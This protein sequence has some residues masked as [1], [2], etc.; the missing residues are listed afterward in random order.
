[1][2][3]L[4]KNRHRKQHSVNPCRMQAIV[5]GPFKRSAAIIFLQNCRTQCVPQHPAYGRKDWNGKRG[6]DEWYCLYNSRTRGASDCCARVPGVFGAF[7]ATK[8]TQRKTTERIQDNSLKVENYQQTQ[9][10]PKLLPVPLKLLFL[11]AKVRATFY[12]PRLSATPPC[13]R[14]E[15]FV[16]FPQLTRL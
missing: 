3:L 11:R 4:K 13:K 6:T 2:V 8:S 16:L 15:L 9:T 7:C 14:W 12:P 1:M 10:Y 5:R